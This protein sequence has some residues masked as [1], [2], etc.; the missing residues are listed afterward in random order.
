VHLYQT[1]GIEVYF[2]SLIAR[3]N[4][5]LNLL[6]GKSSLEPGTVHLSSQTPVQMAKL[7]FY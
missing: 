5:N 1:E 4:T 2:T 3:N 7:S 6:G